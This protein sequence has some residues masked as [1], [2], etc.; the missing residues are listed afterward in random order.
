MWGP[1]VTVVLHLWR[2]TRRKPCLVVF[3]RCC[4][5]VAL[6]PPKFHYRTSCPLS[7]TCLTLHKCN[8]VHCACKKTNLTRSHEGGGRAVIARDVTH[9]AA[10][11]M[12]SRYMGVSQLQLG[13]SRYTV[14]LCLKDGTATIHS[15]TNTCTA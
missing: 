2:Y 8:N 6:R 7:P 9:R 15:G 14:P 1:P 3:F 12:V 5:G 10:S 13:V 11:D 4:T